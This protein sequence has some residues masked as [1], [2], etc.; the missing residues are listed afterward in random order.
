MTDDDQRFYDEVAN[1]LANNSVKP[2]LWTRAVSES[3]DEGSKARA[4]YIRLRFLE[5]KNAASKESEAFG[6]S[7]Y[8]PQVRTVKIRGTLLV[9]CIVI[10]IVG[11]L[12]AISSLLNLHDA[13]SPYFAHSWYYHAKEFYWAY[14][15]YAVPLFFYQII[16]GLVVWT[17]SPQGRRWARLYFRIRIIFSAIMV[18]VLTAYKLNMGSYLSDD[19]LLFYFRMVIVELITFIFWMT[20][21]SKSRRVKMTYGDGK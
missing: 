17:G 9:F 1:E 21:L 18:H 12:G 15:F 11:P 20:Y 13:M 14:C 5:L 6:G 2:G 16:T 19:Y 10:T 8:T 4:A 3:G 7:T